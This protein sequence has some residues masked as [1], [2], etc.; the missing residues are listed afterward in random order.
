MAMATA[1]ATVPITERAGGARV[2]VVIVNYRTPDLSL[3]ALRSVWAE[4]A[5]V[6]GLQALLVDGGSGDGSADR[7]RDALETAPDPDTELLPLP[8]NGGFGHANNQALGRLAAAPHPPAYVCLLNPDARLLPGS[9]DRLVG[10]LEQR[11]DVAAVGAQLQGEDGTRQGSAFRFP[12]IRGEFC[13]GAGTDL[14]RRLLRQPQPV[15]E[16]SEAGPVPWVTGAAVLFRMA[17]LAEVGLFDTGF[18]LYFEEVELMHRL[19]AAG[20]DIWHDPDARVIHAGGGSTDIQWGP[21][22]FH[23]RAALPA[24]WYASRRRYFGRTGGRARVVAAGLAFLAGRAI[25]QARVLVQRRRDGFPLRTSRDTARLS[26][27]PRRADGIGHV[28]RL[29]DVPGRLPGWMVDA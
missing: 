11:P 14:L 20:W 10:L 2:A 27:W 19:R 13:R 25:W 3:A 4:R 8:V 7:L 5:Q 29:D 22:G 23:K 12:T 18:F 9:L 21:D 24:Y 17:A 6:P 26:L 28:G 16:R 1:T 15:A